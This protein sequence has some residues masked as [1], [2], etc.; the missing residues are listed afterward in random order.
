MFRKAKRYFTQSL[1]LRPLS[2]YARPL[3]RWGVRMYR[4]GFFTVRETA[5]HQTLVR[6]AALSFYTLISVVP[7]LALI[8]AVLKALGMIDNLLED[9]YGL[10]PENPEIIDYIVDFA[11]KT[12]DRTRG[13]VVAAGGVVILFW[14]VIRVFGSIESAFNNIWEVVRV[15]SIARQWALYIGIVLVVPVLWATAEALGDHF[16]RLID[17]TGRGWLRWAVGLLSVTV[18]WATF[19]L[20][21]KWI[22]YTHVRTRSALTAGIAA[23]TAF[24]LFQWGYIYLQRLM[25]SYNAV[26]GSFAALPLFLLWLQI[27]WQI[28]L[29]GG[30]LA[31]AHQHMELFDAERREAIESA[32]LPD[33]RIKRRKR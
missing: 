27:S 4:L 19:A 10:F 11:E 28:L 24:L 16:F 6:S 25:T 30:E 23:G 15:R 26:Y 2:A 1:F 12:L 21:Y 32:P 29:F 20:L 33:D 13:G 31:Y 8:F 5:E 22:P 3:T 9:L 7:I 14:A 18:M 17:P